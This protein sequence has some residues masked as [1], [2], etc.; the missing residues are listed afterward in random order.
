MPGTPSDPGAVHDPAPVDPSLAGT[1]LGGRYRIGEPIG[2]GAMGVVWT[3]WD[4]RLRRTVAVKQLVGSASARHADPA[5]PTPARLIRARTLREGRL[6]GRVVHQRAI[7]VFDVVVPAGEREAPWLVME[8]LPSRSLATV[9]AEQGPLEPGQVAHIGAQIAD[10]LAAV[11]DAGIVHGDVKPGNVL[12]GADGIAKITDFGVSRAWWDTTATAGGA[13]A[14]TPGYVAPEVARGEDPTTASDVFSF[15]ATLYAAVE[16]ELVC[17]TLPNQLAV[18]HAMAE[19]RLRPAVRAGSLGRPLAAMLRIGAE[20]RP[21]MRGV[22]GALQARASATPIPATPIPA[23][24]IPATPVPDGAGPETPAVPDE[25]PAEPVVPAEPAV[26]VEPAGPVTPVG[27][28]AAEP[29]GPPARPG[30][31]GRPGGGGRVVT[32]AAA[33]AAA[34]ILGAGITLAGPQA[35][36]HLADTS[37]PHTG[38]PAPAPTRSPIAAPPPT[39]APAPS[40]PPAPSTSAAAPVS[41][42]DVGRTVAGYYGALPDDVDAAWGTLSDGARSDSGGY[43]DYVRFWQGIDDVSADDIRVDGTS[44]IAEIDFVTAGGRSSRETY[45]FEVGRADD[46]RLQI[47]SA[48]RSASVM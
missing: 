3:A 38:A 34:L 10:A 27:P 48:R 44:A 22:H 1:V 20:H 41:T 2:S 19:G 29:A 14:G 6:A 12:I 46:G 13:V 31:D 15:G 28:V 21:D 25:R 17:G 7:A 43:D 37:R 32:V 23:T 47:E 4:Q 16:G 45:R 33:A 30:R 26:A 24:P 8:Y 5:D 42:D 39:A 9:L 35:L 40:A 36:T 11:H 18:L